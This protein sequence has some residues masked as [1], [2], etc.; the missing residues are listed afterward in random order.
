MLCK[1]GVSAMGI[2]RTLIDRNLTKQTSHEKKISTHFDY[3]SV[4]K[5]YSLSARIAKFFFV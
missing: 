5:Y 1:T 2:G 3:Y 4:G